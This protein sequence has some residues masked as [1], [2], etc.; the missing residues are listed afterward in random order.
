MVGGSLLHGLPLV[1]L[2]KRFYLFL[3]LFFETMHLSERLQ[4]F[5]KVAF[6]FFKFN[7]DFCFCS[8]WQLVHSFL[9]EKKR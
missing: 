1:G 4:T 9:R 3:F 2:P 8:Y 6:R 7:T 5:K